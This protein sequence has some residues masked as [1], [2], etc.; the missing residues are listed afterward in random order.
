MTIAIIITAGS[1]KIKPDDINYFNPKIKNTKSTVSFKK[2]FF[3]KNIYFF[4][5]KFNDIAVFK[6]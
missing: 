1:F 4:V 2:V 6:K 3:Y 5:D